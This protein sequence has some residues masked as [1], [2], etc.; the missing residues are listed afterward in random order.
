M[1]EKPKKVIIIMDSRSPSNIT[2]EANMPHE[3]IKKV[4]KEK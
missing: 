3:I 2:V 1:S 4:I